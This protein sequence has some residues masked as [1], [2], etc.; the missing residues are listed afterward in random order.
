MKVQLPEPS[1]G[2]LT[3]NQNKRLYSQTFP[4]TRHA[5]PLPTA[6][7]KQEEAPPSLGDQ[8]EFLERMMHPQKRLAS[9]FSSGNSNLGSNSLLINGVF[10]MRADFRAGF[11][12]SN[13]DKPRFD[14]PPV[15]LL[16]NAHNSDNFFPANRYM[17]P[18]RLLGQLPPVPQRNTDNNNTSYYLNI[19]Q[20]YLTKI[21]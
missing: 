17:P 21:Q 14:G 19:I 16:T 4:E 10:P 13:E 3:R 2:A 5:L 12:A 9:N 6:F 7:I 15:Q 11:M 1:H 20:S 18:N 8:T